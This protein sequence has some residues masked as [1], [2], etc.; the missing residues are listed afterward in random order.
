MPITPTVAFGFCR[1]RIRKSALGAI[2][3]AAWWPA[4][5]FAE[6]LTGNA[7]DV[8][9]RTVK[10]LGDQALRLAEDRFEE[11]VGALITEA[12]GDSARL[13][14]AAARL[15]TC[16]PTQGASKEQIAFALLMEA[17]HRADVDDEQRL[18]VVG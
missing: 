18:R 9:D 17:A 14:M 2:P 16:G 6:P 13:S 1:H 8:D 10:E 3:P 5:R 15:S 7:H 11:R 12:R 4:R